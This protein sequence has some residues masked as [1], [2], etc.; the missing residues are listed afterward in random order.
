MDQITVYSVYIAIAL[1]LAIG[2][3]AAI[4]TSVAI[5]RRWG[6]LSLPMILILLIAGGAVGVLVSGRNLSGDFS[7]IVA[8]LESGASSRWV[9]RG[10]ITLIVVLCIGVI[11]GRMINRQRTPLAGTSLFVGFLLYY[12]TMSLLPSVFG[13]EPAFLHNQIYPLL[14]MV[15]VFLSDRPTPEQFNAFAKWLLFAFMVASMITAIVDPNLALELNYQGWIPG[16]KLR[17]WGLASH[18]NVLGPVA[19]TLLLL[20]YMQPTRNSL[21]RAALILITLSAL[22]LTQSKTTWLAGLIVMGFLVAYRKV[23]EFTRAL[24]G[25]GQVP[26]SSVFYLGSLLFVLIA[27]AAVLLTVNTDRLIDNLMASDIGAGLET[28][29]GRKLIWETALQEWKNNWLFGYGPLIWGDMYRFQHGMFTYAFHAHNQV[30][31]SVSMGGGFA[32]FG[33]L[34]YVW[35]LW[36]YSVRAA[37]ATRGVSIA[38]LLLAL[39][40]SMSEVPFPQHAVFS[41]DFHLHIVMVMVLLLNGS[42]LRSRH[43]RV[44]QGAGLPVSNVLPVSV[45]G[46]FGIALKR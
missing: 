25:G 23:P 33:L 16:F 36:R 22:V 14:V 39:I 26:L 24:R 1:L 41:M 13:T 9:N 32:L 15:A 43:V 30:L 27:L 21:L 10:F 18:A 19:L 4:V 37:S 12:I 31:Q 6:E 3:I 29:S 2:V 44:H 46:G 7:I 20:E 8:M 17:L 45:G 38:L 35:L 42:P 40:R 34:A 28:A 11:V 5:G